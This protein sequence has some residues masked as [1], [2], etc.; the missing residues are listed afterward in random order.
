MSLAEITEALEEIPELPPLPGVVRVLGQRTAGGAHEV[1]RFSRDGRIVLASMYARLSRAYDVRTGDLLL[2]TSPFT[3]IDQIRANPKRAKWIAFKFA[4]SALGHLIRL[5]RGMDPRLTPA[6]KRLV[7]ELD[8][9]TGLADFDTASRR[10]KKLEDEWA[11]LSPDG[12]VW[13][14]ADWD[15]EMIFYD[16]Q[17]GQELSRAKRKPSGTE[18]SARALSDDG[19]LFAAEAKRG[20]VGIWEVATGKLAKRLKSHSSD[21]LGLAISPCGTVLATAGGDGA[22]VLWDLESGSWRAR[23]TG[24][25]EGPEQLAF[26]RHRERLLLAT[27]DG[28]TLGLFEVPSL[29]AVT[30]LGSAAENL[31]LTAI[32]ASPDGSL[33][34]AGRLDDTV[35]LLDVEALLA[36]PRRMESDPVQVVAE[37]PP[38]EEDDRRSAAAFRSL[39]EARFMELSEPLAAELLALADGAAG[40]AR[41]VDF[42]YDPLALASGEGLPWHTRDE[43]GK[44][45]ASGTLA[46]FSAPLLPEGALDDPKHQSAA[47]EPAEVLAKLLPAWLASQWKATTP[48][49]PRGFLIPED[50][51]DRYDLRRGRWQYAGE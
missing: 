51:E 15:E 31:G 18:T 45:L 20:T 44:E 37:G 12:R 22:L 25:E 49:L 41:Q 10:V 29:A 46:A 6:G 24:W 26:L 34:A 3:V 35:H 7:K 2:E 13:A 19:R 47:A 39:L 38:T 23:Q 30:R 5:G 1:V 11:L 4:V 32:G 16:A 8:A 28:W 17:T 50:G 27:T 43:A 42:Y 9:P 33:L 48:A 14:S 21:V 40:Q 36:E